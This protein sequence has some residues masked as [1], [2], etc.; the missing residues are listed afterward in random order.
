V[1]RLRIR[2]IAQS[3]G[4]SMGL[5]SRKS[6]VTINVVRQV[7]RNDQYDISFSTL[8]KIAAALGVRVQDLIENGEEPSEETQQE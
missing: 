3:K 6:N 5:L 4:I 2:E 8:Q 7:W 1:A